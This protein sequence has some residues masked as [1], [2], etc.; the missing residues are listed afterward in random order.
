MEVST[1][2]VNK[3]LEA[4]TQNYKGPRE[5]LITLIKTNGEG[6]IKT[7]GIAG[8]VAAPIGIPL[9][10]AVLAALSTF[11]LFFWAICSTCC[12]R[13]CCLKPQKEGDAKTAGQKCVLITSVLVGL[14]LIVTT[15]VW[16]ILVSGSIS[17]IKNFPCAITILYSDIVRGYKGG[18]ENDIQFIG[19]GGVKFLVDKVEK[20]IDNVFAQGAKGMTGI[21][22]IQRGNALTGKLNDFYNDNKPDTNAGRQMTADPSSNPDSIKALGDTINVA[23]REEIKQL[24]EI[25]KQFDV[26]RVELEKAQSGQAADIKNAFS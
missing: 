8:S 26:A 13:T 9:V 20:A 15:V 17:T 6:T 21:D 4:V 3:D 25:G 12:K 19:I 24:N 22:Y 7:D 16:C 1:S 14:A 23:L 2:D 5:A 18:G 11:F 10:F